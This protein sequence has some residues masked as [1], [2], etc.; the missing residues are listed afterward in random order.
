MN[1]YFDLENVGAFI[2]QKDHKLYGDCLKTMQRQLDVFF[3]FKKEELIKNETLMAW[4]KFFTSNVGQSNKQK[5]LEEKF[6]ERPLKSNTYLSF[7]RTQ[8]SSMY[9]IHDEKVEVL[10]NMGAVLVGSPGEEINIFHQLFL[11]NEDYKFNKKMEIASAELSCWNDLGKFSL[12][13][14]DILFI[15]PYILSSMELIR[16]NLLPLIQNLVSK[17][18]CKVNLVF[19]VNQNNIDASYSDISKAIRKAVSTVTGKNPNLTI[20]RYVDQRDVSSFAEHDRTI[21]TNYTR[22]YSGDTFNYFKPDG[23]KLTKGRELHIT[24]MAAMENHGLSLSLI[25]SI[26]ANINALP[27]DSVDGDKKSNFLNFK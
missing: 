3:N 11:L 16:T 15:D 12:A 2:E 1:V 22:Y 6:P 21:F 27:A 23:T 17:S 13:T 24:S 7:D 10:K 4:F 18:R 9:L 19:Y 5:F 20:V 25:A 8:L 26:Q 14:S